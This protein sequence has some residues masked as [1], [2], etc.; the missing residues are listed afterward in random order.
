MK[1]PKSSRFYM[2]KSSKKYD[3]FSKNATFSNLSNSV[4]SVPNSIWNSAKES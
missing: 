2:L 4:R 1:Y 3:Y